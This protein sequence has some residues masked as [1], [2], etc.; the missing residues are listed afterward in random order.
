MCD[1][2]SA[3][4]YLLII[5]S[6]LILTNITIL[7]DIPFLRQI[8][9]FFFLTFLPGLLILQILKLNKIGY[10]EK[11]VLSVGLSISF[12][13]FFGLF[14][15]NLSL[16]I[17]Y[18]TPLSTISLLISL[19]IAFIV[20]G[21]IGCKTNKESIFSLPDLNLSTAEKAFLIVPILF[22]ALSMLGTHLMG[23]ADNNIILLFLLF[24]ISLYVAFVCFFNRKFSKRLYPI[25]ILST[26]ISL[27]L[28]FM[29]RFP[30][31]YGQDVHTEYFFFKTT[32]DSLHWNIVGY[33]SLDA[34]LSISLL[35]AIFQ[36]LLNVN[37]QE[38][39]FKGVYVSACSFGP[40]GIYVI[41]KKYIGELYAF[42]ASFFFMS[43]SSFLVTA[44]S[45]RTSLAI[46]F[47]ALAVM[48]FFND[49]IE[50]LKRR[51][52]FIVFMLS[53]VVSHYSTTYLFF[54]IILGAFIG[55]EILS[56]KYTFKKAISLTIVFL[57]FALIFLWYSLVTETAFNVGVGFVEET[58]GNL[59][60]FFVEESR[61][62][63]I[64]MLTGEGLAYPMLSRVC[65]AFTWAT[66]VLIGIGVL[67]MLRR[68][69]EM[70]AMSNV[71]H[72]KPH[73]LKTKFEM[74]YLVMALA[75]AGL[76][77]IMVALPYVSVSYGIQRLYSLVLVILSLFFVLGGMT[78][79]N[80]SFKKKLLLKKQKEG[81][82]VLQNPVRKSVGRENGSQVR[83]Y[84]IILLILIPYF[85]FGTGAMYEIF[86]VSGGATLNSEGEGIDHGYIHNSE[87]CAAKWLMENA[88][89]NSR[90]YTSDYI[91]K[92]GLI[93]QGEILPSR[94]DCRS[95]SKHGKLRGYFYLSYNNVVKEKFVLEG[96]PCNMTEYL[97]MFVGKSK[98]Y[99]SGCAEVY[100]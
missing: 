95:F 40:L 100:K 35:P 45:P 55:T 51:F 87:S 56:K 15:N 34:C 24:L 17:G 62:P 57:F 63:Q 61:A 60:M 30:H 64:K 93:S 1:K 49:K 84:L 97:D 72:K 3:K 20:L 10:T 70:V 50:P 48:V 28:I 13:M 7:L 21:V 90:I 69:K 52:L 99:N 43:Q 68:Y 12:L 2:T 16:S 89:K 54:F 14:V 39:L 42:L 53:V 47:V 5:I 82:N 75:C 25:V 29:L 91:V 31:I 81:G 22:P 80:F 86:G 8:F 96:I 6:I 66:L 59:N 33:T 76:L 88:K 77:V 9:G 44:G 26:S 32:F 23:N 27:L 58:L 36:S 41:S 85:L 11:F 18:E 19:N 65:L 78:L 92:N 46:F 79:S 38:Y 37:A 98:V 94:I 4:N 67:T 74:E 73:F 83:A 71:K